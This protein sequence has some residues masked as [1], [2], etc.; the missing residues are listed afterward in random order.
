MLHQ[1]VVPEN[2]QLPTPW[3]DVGNSKQEGGISRKII[4][5]KCA[6]KQEFPEGSGGGI[7]SEKNIHGV[8]DTSIFKINTV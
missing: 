3:R 8:M 2:I 7:Q 1:C 5:R 6:P 4:S